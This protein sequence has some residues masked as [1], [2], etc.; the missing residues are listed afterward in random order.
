MKERDDARRLGRRVLDLVLRE[1][2]PAG[3]ERV[4]RG[5]SRKS[6]ARHFGAPPRARG[7]GDRA[8]LARLRRVLHDSMRLAHPRLFGLFT[9]APLP[10]AA[11]GD[12]AA[13][14]LNQSPDAWKAGPA[15]TEVE[16][17]L[18][19]TFND[20]AGLP[21][22]AFGVLTSGGGMA[23]LIALKMARD[24]AL[25]LAVRKAGVARRDA[26]RLRVYASQ[27]AHFS[28]ARGL[29][30]LGLGSD[31]LVPVPI[32]PDRRL[33][34][35]RLE[36]T[37][38]RDRRRG[39]RPL[40]IVATAGTTSTGALDPL[41]GMA[42]LARAYGTFF[43]VDAAYGGALLVSRRERQRLAGIAAAD[44]IT[45]DPHKWLFQP[46]SLAMLLVRDGRALHA[47]CAVDPGYLRKDLEAER[48]RIDFFQHSLEGSRPFRGLKL[49]LTLQAIGLEGLAARVERTLDLARHLDACARRDGRFETCGAAV[50]L[51]SVC[52]RYLP[53]W[54]RGLDA[55]A[56]REPGRRARLN[57]LQRRLQQ[58]VER[59][60]RAWFPALWLGDTVWLRF[61]V[62]ND[63]TSA[64]DAEAT[65]AIVARAG[66]RLSRPSSRTG[67]GAAGARRSRSSRGRS[68]G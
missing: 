20:L 28:L 64:R 39:L 67:S 25:G 4:W 61:G 50:D 23:N 34:C 5:G 8:V 41:Q 38:R 13:A 18:V 44:S 45:L 16:A 60:G 46:F 2:L 54:A 12:L 31:A 33:C 3:G 9:P 68:R 66:E 57:A 26:A 49:D 55:A 43:H 63:R 36:E 37:L 59:E 32:G 62:F 58:A 29:D 6:V 22:S 47:S 30:I 1:T 56:L 14:F 51:A 42:R 17:R 24:R 35:D 48:D 7:G 27:E 40:A 53:A 10:V 65:L 52:L 15:A 11:L 21:R 19:R